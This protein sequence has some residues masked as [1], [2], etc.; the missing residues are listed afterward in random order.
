MIK[1]TF[2][3]EPAPG[4]GDK[5]KFLRFLRHDMSAIASVYL[6]IIFA[7][8]KVLLFS[9]HEEDEDQLQIVA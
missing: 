1:P 2:S 9:R 4:Q 5:L 7:P 3:L 8:C 6:P